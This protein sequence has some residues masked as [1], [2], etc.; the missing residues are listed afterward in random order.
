VLKPDVWSLSGPKNADYDSK[1]RLDKA[2]FE[3]RSHITTV[4]ARIEESMQ[5]E[6]VIG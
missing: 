1:D 3:R 5:E 2:R 4:I 6:R